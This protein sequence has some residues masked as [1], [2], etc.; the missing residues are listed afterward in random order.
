MILKKNKFFVN[1]LLFG[2]L[3]SVFN[4]LV[5]KALLFFTDYKIANIVAIISTKVFVYITNK[6]FVFKSSTPSFAALALEM[7]RYTIARGG[8]ALI[9]FFGVILLVSLFKLDPFYSKIILVVIVIIAN[10]IFS[11]KFVFKK[12]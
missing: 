3:S 4:I 7:G 5:F 9:D 8:T 2:L 10:Y 1:Y 12:I 6:L 11:K